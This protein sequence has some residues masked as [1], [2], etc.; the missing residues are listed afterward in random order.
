VN[1]VN[2]T[3]K[4]RRFGNRSGRTQDMKKAYVRLADGQSIDY[5][6]QGKR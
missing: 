5:E 2:E 4:S 6:A 3:G 1:I